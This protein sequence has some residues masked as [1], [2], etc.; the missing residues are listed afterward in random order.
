MTLHEM[1]VV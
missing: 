1:F